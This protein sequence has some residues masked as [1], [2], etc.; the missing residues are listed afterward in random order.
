MNALAMRII[1]MAIFCLILYVA[2]H[3]NIQHSNDIH[4]E[5]AAIKGNDPKALEALYQRGFPKV[6]K[7]IQENKG[8]SEQ[9]K[10]IFQEAYIAVWRNIQLGK[11]LM[12]NET[13]L[14]GYLYKIAKN[15]WLDFLRS[16]YHKKTVMDGG[17][18]MDLADELP[19]D[20]EDYINDIKKHF[21]NLGENCKEVLIRYYYKNEP[22]KIIA[23]AMDWTE[24]T[25]RNN[26]Y[27][28]IER[29]REMIKPRQS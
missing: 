27:R 28:C 20:Q 12:Q 3:P 6:L 4:Q 10:D 14:D 25:A 8:S 29:L 9:A 13:A 26:K 5:L 15:K 24:A 19:L 23:K 16:S 7:Y 2:M 22:L 21:K 1:K 11:F 17:T 18:A